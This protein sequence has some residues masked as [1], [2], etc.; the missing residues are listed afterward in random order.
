MLYDFRRVKRPMDW[1]ATQERVRHEVSYDMV[2]YGTDS[3]L[4]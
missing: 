3:A 4:H 1:T 2:V